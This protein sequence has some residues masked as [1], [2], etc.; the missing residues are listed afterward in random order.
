MKFAAK[1]FVILA[2]MGAAPAVDRLPLERGIYVDTET[3]CADPPNVDV[4]SYWGG[5]NAINESHG[6]CTITHLSRARNVYTVRSH[7]SGPQLS[8]DEVNTV[9]V[10]D[11]HTFLYAN[12]APINRAGLIPLNPHQ[13][14]SM[15]AP[16]ATRYRWC[17]A[18]L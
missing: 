5:N 8:S 4:L 17:A 6:R 13:P 2:T 11:R 16:N 15:A 1:A 10:I 3:P 14:A 18:K 12:A 7:C 9:T